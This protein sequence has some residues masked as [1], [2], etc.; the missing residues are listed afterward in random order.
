MEKINNREYELISM[1]KGGKRQYMGNFEQD[2]FQKGRM[3]VIN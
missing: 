2:N 3:K 1:T